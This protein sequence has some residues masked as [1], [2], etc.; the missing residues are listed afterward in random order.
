MRYL[1]DDQLKSINDALEPATGITLGEVGQMGVKLGDLLAFNTSDAGSKL[2]IASQFKKQ[3]NAHLAAA[4][5]VVSASLE[6]IKAKEAI[7]AEL[8]RAGKSEPFKWGQSVW[9]RLLVSSPQPLANVAGFTQFYA[10]QTVADM[11][12]V[13]LLLW[14]RVWVRLPQVTS[15]VRK[16]S[17]RHVL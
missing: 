2:Q 15:L 5:D 17:V 16:A 12:N 14:L 13:L 3:L 6:E 10:G 9:K 11:F 4:N 7:E 1:D 8:K